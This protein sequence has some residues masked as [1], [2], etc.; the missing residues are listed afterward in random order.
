MQLAVGLT[1]GLLTLVIAVLGAL[2]YLRRQRR[3][4]LD[5]ALLAQW[6]QRPDP[7]QETKQP[8]QLPTQS[9]GE[10][11]APSV[12]TMSSAVP[13]PSPSSETFPEGASSTP[14]EVAEMAQTTSEKIIVIEDEVDEVGEVD[15][16]L[17]AKQWWDIKQ[18]YWE[19][20]V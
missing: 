14:G 7:S 12:S 16:R 18:F 10:L 3:R 13:D 1:V 5:R 20:A 4:K 9:S 15:E 17:K 2:W 6:N 11:V 19:S 8:T